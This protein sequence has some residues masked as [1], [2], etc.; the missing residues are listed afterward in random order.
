MHSCHAFIVQKNTVIILFLLGWIV[1]QSAKFKFVM[2]CI[3][4]IGWLFGEVVKHNLKKI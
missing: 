1:P 3:M 2:V 4:D